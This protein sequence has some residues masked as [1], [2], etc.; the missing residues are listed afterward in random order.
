M[1]ADQWGNL[2]GLAGT[3]I[4]IFPAIKA[5]QLFFLAERAKGLMVE[6]PKE[7]DKLAEWAGQVNQS[8]KELPAEWNRNDVIRLFAGIAL[9]G[10]SDLLPL[11]KSWAML[12]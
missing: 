3:V 2:A 6:L 10:L 4:L 8:A 7:Q 12:S 11:L 1:S 9:T 5:T